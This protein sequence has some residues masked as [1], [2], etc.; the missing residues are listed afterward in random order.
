MGNKIGNRNRN[1]LSRQPI[2][3]R[4]QKSIGNNEI[5]TGTDFF[6]NQVCQWKTGIRNC[7]K[8]L[9]PENRVSRGYQSWGVIWVIQ[10]GFF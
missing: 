10:T 8:P 5:C 3:N 4:M 9:S 6:V 7:T 2:G 1:G